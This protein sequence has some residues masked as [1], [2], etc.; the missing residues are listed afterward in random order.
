MCVF[1]VAFFVYLFG[2][3][4]ASFSMGR[5]FE[6]HPV[7]GRDEGFPFDPPEA[8]GPLTIGAVLFHLSR[9]WHRPTRVRGSNGVDRPVRPS[10]VSIQ[11]A[12]RD[13]LS[14]AARHGWARMPHETPDEYGRRLAGQCP[15]AGPPAAIITRLYEVWR[16]GGRDCP[17]SD[18][19]RADRALRQLELV[20]PP[21]E[22]E[23]RR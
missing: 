14:W 23:A 1:A 4:R 6:F 15:D 22:A 11:A 18:L 7:E 13:L 20:A 5:I 12:Y 8:R 17:P 3:V 19:Q 10:P 16:Y 21:P 9:L 2:L